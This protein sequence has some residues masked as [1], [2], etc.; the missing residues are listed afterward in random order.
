MTDARP[1]VVEVEWRQD[2][3]TCREIYGPWAPAEDDSH[4]ESMKRFVLGWQDKSGIT[5][6]LVTLWLCV[7]PEEWLAGNAV[8]AAR[9]VA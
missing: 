7:D 8:S 3:E 4:L 6:E 9:P 1:L 2:G 5:P